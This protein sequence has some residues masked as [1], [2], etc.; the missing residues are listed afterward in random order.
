MIAASA[1]I[2]I[3]TSIAAP[4]GELLRARIT[5]DEGFDHIDDLCREGGDSGGFALAETIAETEGGDG[6]ESV[7]VCLEVRAEGLGFDL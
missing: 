7:D 1:L 2:L 5:E 6:G 4:L 3:A